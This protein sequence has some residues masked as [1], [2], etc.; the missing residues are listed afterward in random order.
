MGIFTRVSDIVSAN[1]NDIVERFESPETMLCQAIREMDCAIA[2]TMEATAKAIADER[3]IEHEL[4]RHREQ[5]A[6]LLACARAAVIRSDESAARRALIRRQEHE[7]LVAALDD[8]LVRVRSTT[9]KIRRQLDA[10]RFRRMEAQRTLHVLIARDRAV[11]ARRE[12]AIHDD[13]GSDVSGLSRFDRLRRKI[14]RREAETDALIELAACGEVEIPEL[15][16]DHEVESLLQAI[17]D[18]VVAA[19][20]K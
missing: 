19:E 17:K 14:E 9:G 10:M 20:V 12:L 4:A 2:R 5:S 18:E 11:A 6:V 13:C 15:D 7:K 16:S 3:L 1:L 8:Q